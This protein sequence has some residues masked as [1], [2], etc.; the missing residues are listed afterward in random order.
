MVVAIKIG[1]RDETPETRGSVHFLEHSLFKGS[2]KQTRL[3]IEKGTEEIGGNLN[4]WTSRDSMNVILTVFPHLLP[5][6]IEI[7][8]EMVGQSVL[9]ESK[10]N[11]EKSTILQELIHVHKDAVDTCLDNAHLASFYDHQI[12]Q[13]ILGTI[14]SIE[15]A[16]LAGIKS[17]YNSYFVSQNIVIAAAGNLQ[18][19][20]L[21]DNVKRIFRLQTDSPS[22][23][24]NSLQKPLPPK[25]DPKTLLVQNREDQS[26][27]VSF[28]ASFQAPSWE[29]PDYFSF[30]ILQR[31]I[32]DYSANNFQPG[33]LTPES[34][35]YNS[36]HKELA[37]H[38][39]IYFSKCQY[40]PYTDTGLISVYLNGSVDCLNVMVDIGENFLKTF[41]HSILES[42]LKRAKNKLFMELM[43]FETTH[44]LAQNMASQILFL[45]R[46]VSRSELAEK[47]SLIDSAHLKR[48]AKKWLA[49]DVIFF[50]FFSDLRK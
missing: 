42:E 22:S 10:I 34:P 7:V 4:A 31:I 24:T 1:S 32:G 25:F 29:D 21:I 26:G 6:A 20:D 8:S 3:Q 48:V 37:M 33:Q 43:Q 28:C 23:S 18:H 9:T 38:S 50:I 11:R 49:K 13:P 17:F 41:S 39:D 19:E 46:I 14:E 35:Q 2:A 30:L 45:D 27:T 12:G 5:K 40:I 36:M 15:S 16:Q 47:I 44:D